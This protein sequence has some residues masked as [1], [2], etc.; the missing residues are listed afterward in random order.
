[1][2]NKKEMVDHP[3]HYNQNKFEV[4]DEMVMLFGIEDVKTFCKLNAYKYKSRAPFK[5]NQEQDLQKADW[6]LQRYLDLNANSD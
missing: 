4:I 3:A 6:Y 2:I 1:M 5:G